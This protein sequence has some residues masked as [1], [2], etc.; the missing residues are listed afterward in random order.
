MGI[1]TI[2][3]ERNPDLRFLY[4]S[5]VGTDRSEKGRSMWARMKGRTENDL[6][7]LSIKAAD[8][9]RP[10]YLHP[11]PG[12]LHIQPYYRYLSWMYPL[13]RVLAPNS[14]CTLLEFSETIICV[15]KHGHPSDIITIK[16][17]RS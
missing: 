17:T 15:A 13:L 16:D 6:L 3:T 11:I 9:V 14:A 5:G 7:K 4:V 10:G 2:L 12:L 1:A 8:G